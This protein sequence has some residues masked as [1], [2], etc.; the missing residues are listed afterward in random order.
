MSTSAVVTMAVGMV[1][2][3][4]GLAASIWL[5][6]SRSARNRNT[7]SIPGGQDDH[8]PGAAER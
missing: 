2:I 8:G 3:W 6:L 7:R 4:G 1:A 5:A